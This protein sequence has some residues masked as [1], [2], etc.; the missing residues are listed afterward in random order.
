MTRDI[1]RFLSLGILATSLLVPFG[2]PCRA[3]DQ[4]AEPAVESPEQGKPA[5]TPHSSAAPKDAKGH[6]AAPAAK[7]NRELTPE[8]AAFRDRV[9]AVLEAHRQDGFNTHDNSATEVLNVCLGY[10]CGTVIAQSTADGNQPINGISCLCWNYPCNGFQLLI[11]QQGRVAARIGYGY[12]EHPG[13]FL[14]MLAMSRVPADYALHV[15]PNVP[16]VSDL[17]ETEKLACRRGGDLSLVLVG[18]VHY[19][20][21]S[22]WKNDLGETWSIERIVAEELS[23]PVVGAAE[24]GMNRLLGLGYAVSRRAKRGGAMEG[25]WEQAR[26]YIDDFQNFAFTTQNAD[27]SWGPYFLSARAPARDAATQLRSTGRALEWLAVSLPDKRLEDPRVTAALDIVTSLLE[28]QT[29]RAS[30]PAL[31]TRD[32]ASLGHALHALSIYDER[33]FQPADPPPPPATAQKGPE[34][35]G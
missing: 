4:S 2:R 31:S 19:A 3:D 6:A 23:Q 16:K 34:K 20:D 15:G 5:E 32:I 10:G 18:L 30:P 22:S 14:A 26:K 8:L 17:V 33:V 29:F 21:Q 35:R 9:R 12:Q 7:P 24:G 1:F 11:G 13:E 28:S 27:G 25:R